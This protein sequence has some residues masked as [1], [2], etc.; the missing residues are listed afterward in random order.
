MMNTVRISGS[1]VSFTM[2]SCV[3]APNWIPGRDLLF[4]CRVYIRIS[5]CYCV[6]FLT[7]ACTK[8]LLKWSGRVFSVLYQDSACLHTNTKNIY[9]CILH[10]PALIEY[11]ELEDSFVKV[12]AA[13]QESSIQWECRPFYNFAK[14]LQTMHNAGNLL[15]SFLPS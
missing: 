8:L 14:I 11:I 12:H 5:L 2:K 13:C 9:I 15:T 4:T 3:C 6:L 10:T 7:N 1:N